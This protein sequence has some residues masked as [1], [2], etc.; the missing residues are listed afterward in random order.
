MRW[1]RAGTRCARGAQ[2]GCWCGAAAPDVV[3]SGLYTADNFEGRTPFVGF[4]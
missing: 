4:E 1:C 3:A 2:R